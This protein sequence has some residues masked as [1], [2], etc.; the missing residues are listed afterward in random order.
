M[1]SRP[2][3]WFNA[4]MARLASLPAEERLGAL[5][6]VLDHVRTHGPATRASLIAETGLTRSV[7]TQRVGELV[8]YGLLVE[9]DLAP[10]T[11]GRAPRSIRFRADAGHL[12][13]ADLGAT[14]IDVAVTDLAGAI[15]AH[16]AEPSDIAAGPE[17]V[18]GR[19]DELFQACLREAGEVPGELWAI[20]IGLPGPVEFES[21]LPVSPPIMPGWDRFPVRERF[22]G[23][24]VPVWV[25]N[26]VNLMAL[27]EL[28]AGAA[29]GH[30]TVVFVKIG[31]GI[32]AGIVVGGNLHRGAQ[33]AAGDVGHIQVVEEASGVFCRCGNAGCLEAVAG[34]AALARD[35]EAAARAGRSPVVARLLEQKGSIEARDVAYA[36]THGDPVSAELIANAGRL[37]GRMLAAIVNVFNPSLIV[38]GGG[39]S[40]SGDA[41][42]A[43]IRETVYRRSLPL[44]TR[45]LLVQRST[46]DGLGG[47]IGA[48]AMV[49]GE[50][51]APARLARWIDAGTPRTAVAR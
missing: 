11:G 24:G 4:A 33:G 27:G 14:S 15:V 47:V 46:L 36:A 51:F 6:T 45:D 43:T 10:S 26:D 42:L 9:G 23:Y 3:T 2:K 50:L 21:G 18:L 40:G 17:S 35:A 13:V 5:V 49:T 19:V 31:T 41:L 28:S 29:R 32:G 39:V 1:D 16:L 25:D 44:A 8:D 48:A 34:G 20:G 12:L 7:V 30:D 22:E 38:V 37:I